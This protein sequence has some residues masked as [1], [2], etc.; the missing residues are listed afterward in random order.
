MDIIEYKNTIIEFFKNGNPSNEYYEEM[1]EAILHVAES[2]SFRIVS[3]I[4][5]YIDSMR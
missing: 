3:K 5:A 4:D 1:A 2:N